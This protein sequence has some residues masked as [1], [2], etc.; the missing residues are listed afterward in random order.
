MIQI[1]V[2]N[3]YGHMH[4]LWPQESHVWW[5]LI[6]AWVISFVVIVSEGRQH[7]FWFS[8]SLK[9][10]NIKELNQYNIDNIHRIYI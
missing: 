3:S 2:N 4:D 8:N 9:T 5:Q 10:H 1:N 7:A 6:T